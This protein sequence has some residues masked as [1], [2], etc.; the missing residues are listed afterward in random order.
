MIRIAPTLSTGLVAA[1]ILA[2]ALT[3]TATAAQAACQV[4]YKA[5]RDRPLQLFHDVTTVNVPCAQAEAALRAALAR[6]GL[7]L[8]KVLS[9]RP[10]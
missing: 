5:K 7:T 6:Q 3:L 1:L 10:K 2:L 4:E 8:L 9:K